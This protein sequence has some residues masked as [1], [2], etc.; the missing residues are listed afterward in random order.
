M[1]Q[2]I[3]ILDLDGVLITTPPWK[4]DEIDSDGYSAFNKSC[5]ENL[6]SLLKLIDGKIW[7]SSTRRTVKTLSE[8]NEIFK[9]R[10]IS[11]QIEGFLPEFENCHSRMDE[12]L[13]FLSITNHD[14]YLILDDDK[15]LN[16]LDSKIKQRLILTELMR[17][18][19][20][21]ELQNAISLINNLP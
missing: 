14:N 15:S 5:V 13:K 11:N 21:E 20:A 8:F 6:N 16:D 10:K 7:L 2:V 1:T 19:G 3:I 4:P 18:F 12:V 17:G 9:H